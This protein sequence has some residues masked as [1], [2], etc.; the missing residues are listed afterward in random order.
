M[1][2]KK[3]LLMITAKV[4]RDVI[5]FISEISLI[6][7]FCIVELLGGEDEGGDVLPVVLLCHLHA[8]LGLVSLLL[9]VVEDR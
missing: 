2:T 5:R 6:L 4:R 8:P 7:L 3:I 1:L 9:R